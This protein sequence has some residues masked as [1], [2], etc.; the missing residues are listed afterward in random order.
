MS[1]VA[2]IV[3]ALALA[4]G[5]MLML[6]RCAEPFPIRLT[7]GLAIA[8]ALAL[9]HTV[10][11]LLG[12]GIGDLLR[13]ESPTEASLYNR[14]N[15][16]IMLGLFL[17]VALKMVFPYLKRKPQL[18]V[19]NLTETK[20]VA[21]MAVASGIN[22]LIIGIGVGFTTPLAGHLHIAIWPMLI[23]TLLL[24][25]LGI[26]F[27]RQKVDMRPRRWMIATCVILLGTAIATVVNS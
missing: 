14:P 24:S 10:F 26:M 25:Y 5:D 19:F 11:Y 23:L 4:V 13:I 22:L 12:I 21:A 20:S 27:G 6:R 17:F 15:A 3:V 9:V 1:I 18:A 8:I 16:Y 2:F 7:A